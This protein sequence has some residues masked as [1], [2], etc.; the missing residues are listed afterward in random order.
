MIQ[1]QLSQDELNI[2]ALFLHSSQNR[3]MLE[4]Q[5]G[6]DPKTQDRL[7]KI[8]D[9]LQDRVPDWDMKNDV[10]IDQGPKFEIQDS[11]DGEVFFEG[12]QQECK[13]WLFQRYWGEDGEFIIQ[14][15]GKQ[16]KP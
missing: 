9:N 1:L 4:E 13:D 7:S 6:E 12:T 10:I 11:G 16:T 8:L 15:E 3:E 14:E 2:I 5:F